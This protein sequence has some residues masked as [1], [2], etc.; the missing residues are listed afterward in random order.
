[1][2]NSGRE[3]EDTTMAYLAGVMLA[4][5]DFSNFIISTYLASDASL[6]AA[7]NYCKCRV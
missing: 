2:N 3:N 1:M 5:G 6:P 7:R 4:A